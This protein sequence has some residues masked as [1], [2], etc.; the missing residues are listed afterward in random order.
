MSTILIK[1][2]LRQSVEAASGGEQTV[3]YTA[4]GQPTFVNIIKKFDMSSIDSSMSG[5][6]PAFIVNGVV[7]D[8]IYVGTYAGKLVNGELL[9]LPNV[10]VTTGLS[11]STLDTAAKAC[12]TGFHLITNA[13]WGALIMQSVLA[14]RLP[15][16]N[17]YYGYDVAN[18]A[19]KGRRVDG[20][21]GGVTSGTPRVFS[22]SGDVTW[23]HNQKY[24]G[25][26]DLSGNIN[27]W[28][29]GLRF[30]GGEIQVIENNNAA[31]STT[32]MS[33]ASSSWKA[34]DAITGQLITPNGTGT[35]PTSV[36]IAYAGTS[37]YT[38]VVANNVGLEA[39][40]NPSA[41]PVS[42]NALKVLK[43][44]GIYRLIATSSR[45]ILPSGSNVGYV[46]RG[47]IWTEGVAAGIYRYR[48]DLAKSLISNNLGSRIAYYV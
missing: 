39:M 19:S 38:L 35:T 31:A 30:V 25:V 24:N 40:T 47:G 5:T 26:S 12:G 48:A 9:S 27:E 45:I 17:T 29:A 15:N 11:Y 20:A 6:H 28:V 21:E 1:D 46:S 34:I 42:E 32:D 37:D 2:T 43:A 41:N 10:D 13:E 7:K 8:A 33:D 14:G 4:K 3:L 16:G 44:L 36:K 18:S 22:G 23:R